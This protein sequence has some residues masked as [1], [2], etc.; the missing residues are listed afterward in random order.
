MKSSPFFDTNRLFAWK[1]VY[2]NEWEKIVGDI[3]TTYLEVAKPFYN[4]L[5][6]GHVERDDASFTKLV[7][8]FR[9]AS[10]DIGA[11]LLRECLLEI[12]ELSRKGELEKAGTHM[13]SLNYIYFQTIDEMKMFL[14]F[15]KMNAFKDAA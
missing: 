13:V 15:L 4:G 10:S 11:E 3:L 12:E 1:K 5:L 14:N 2:P 8:E 7:R 6:R 9:L